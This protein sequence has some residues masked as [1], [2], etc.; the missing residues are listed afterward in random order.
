M[1]KRLLHTISSFL[2]IVSLLSFLLPTLHALP[3]STNS[4][5]IVDSNTGQRVKLSCINWSSHLELMV[6]EGLTKQPADVISKKIKDMGF[7]CVRLTYPIYLPTNE[8]L[9]SMTVRQSYLN[10]GLSKCMVADLQAHNPSIVD[11]PLIDA[12]QAV[13]ASLAKNKVMV[14]LDNHVSK[15]QWCCAMT[16][17][18]GFFGDK[19][20]DPEV[21]IKGLT[22]MATIFRD[23]PYVIGMSLR[24]ELRGPRQNA[25]DWYMQR[26]AEAIHKANPNVLVILSGLSYDSDLTF[27]KTKPVS[28]SFTGKLAFEVHQYSF[29]AGLDWRDNSAN[30]VCGN[31][32]ESLMN[33]AGFLLEQ[34][35]PVYVGE[36]GL[37]LSGTSKDD[38]KFFNCFLAL[39]VEHDLDWALWTLAGSYNLR[40]GIIGDNEAFGLL[41]W[42]WT[43]VR[44]TTF[45]Q[46]ISV[47]Q[48]PHRGP[49]PSYRHTHKIIFHPSTGQCIVKDPV[50]GIKLGNCFE[51]DHWIYTPELTIGIKDSFHCLKAK[52][53]N[54]RA[55]LATDCQ[56][57][58][59]RWLPISASK[60]HLATELSYNSIACLDVDSNNT[61]ITT[62][63]KCLSIDDNSCDPG[64]QWFKIAD[65]NAV[66][67]S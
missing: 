21:W 65:A 10:N 3:L 20:F 34:G 9:A 11:L 39:A 43:D 42:N 63:C 35:Y 38:R 61:L 45:L 14:I 31:M 51:S 59:T 8:T 26:G 50:K 55:R 2:C 4:R 15:P 66:T 30:Q 60:L 58:G 49:Y 7:N 19:Y 54:H 41:T 27:L 52:G 57:G 12:I 47:I 18:N 24:N 62:T 6:A 25:D 64:S 36:W 33:N 1:G 17:G 29:S 46:K 23:N 5:W 32:T 53:L 13:V 37:P 67:T 44:N 16:D 40:E 28:L 56:G 48:S 22:R